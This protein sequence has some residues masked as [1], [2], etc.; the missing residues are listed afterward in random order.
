MPAPL[1]LT[2]EFYF[3]SLT[4]GG[5]GWESPQLFLFWVLSGTT[6]SPALTPLANIPPAPVLSKVPQGQ[7]G[8]MPAS[9]HGLE[10]HGWCQRWDILETTRFTALSFLVWVHPRKQRYE[11]QENLIHLVGANLGGAVTQQKVTF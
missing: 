3:A 7:G 9:P 4:S 5:Q 2:K 11:A 1:D 6:P 10:F 8:A